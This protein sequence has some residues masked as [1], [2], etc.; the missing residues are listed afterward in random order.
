MRGGLD[1]SSWQNVLSTLAGIAVFAL[2]GIGIRLLVMMRFQQRRE[3]MN[4]QI[5][6]RLKVLMAA[7]RVLGGSFT[8]QLGV[9]PMHRRDLRQQQ[10]EGGLDADDATGDR[11]RRIRD[12]VEGALSDIFLL[13]TE[14]Q[15][16][17]AERAARDLAEGREVR[18]AQLVV[19]LR[20]YIRTALDLDPIPTGLMIPEQGPTRPNSGGGGGKRD[21]TGGGKSGGG[22]GGMGGGGA[23]M[24]AGMGGGVGPGSTVDRAGASTT[25]PLAVS[26]PLSPDDS[27]DPAR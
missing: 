12:A 25:D 9:S 16:R 20:D 10:T 4:R 17:L 11:G 21:G 27:T 24:G 3:R 7:Y 22:G 5:N 23:G 2:V 6:E 13:G 15:V 8:G 18:T 14:E 19:S 1:F 26:D